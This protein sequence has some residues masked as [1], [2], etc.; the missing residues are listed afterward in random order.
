VE[1]Q[2]VAFLASNQGGKTALAASFMQAGWPLMTDDLLA[3]QIVDA[4]PGPPAILAQPSY[5]Q[6]RMWQDNARFFVGSGWKD[7]P[8][9]HRRYPKYRVAVGASGIGCFADRG[10]PLKALVIPERVSSPVE[11]PPRVMS[12]SSSEAVLA[13]MRNTFSPVALADRDSQGERLGRV[14]AVVDSVQTVGL[15]YAEGHELLGGVRE[16]LLR[17]LNDGAFAHAP[18]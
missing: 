17:A 13:I 18:P 16:G 7:L 11:D 2:V 10:A 12:L 9:V 15:R 3:L 1:G 8:I 6:M 14:A 4:G 5:P